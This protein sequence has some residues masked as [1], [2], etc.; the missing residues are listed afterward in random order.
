[1]TQFTTYSSEHSNKNDDAVD[2]LATF[3]ANHL[4]KFERINKKAEGIH[5]FARL[6]L[7]FSFFQEKAGRGKSLKKEKTSA[8]FVL[9]LKGRQR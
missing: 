1:M 9:H 6:P 8:H 5:H 2:S 7:P 4:T 3:T